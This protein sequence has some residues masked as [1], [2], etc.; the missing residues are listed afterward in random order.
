MN[1]NSELSNKKNEKE[2]T[3]FLV[4]GSKPDCQTDSDLNSTSFFS[5]LAVTCILTIGSH[6]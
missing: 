5:M 2:K 3:S 1:L 4:F 6:Y